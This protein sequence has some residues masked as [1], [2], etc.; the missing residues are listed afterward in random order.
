MAVRSPVRLCVVSVCVCQLWRGPSWAMKIFPC[1]QETKE[2]PYNLWLSDSTRV[3]SY[4]PRCS[5]VRVHSL[6]HLPRR[7]IPQKIGVN[8]RKVW[9]M[10]GAQ[11]AHTT[12]K[13]TLGK[14]EQ[15]EGIRVRKGSFK[16]KEEIK[17]FLY[18]E[19]RQKSRWGKNTDDITREWGGLQVKNVEKA[20][21]GCLCG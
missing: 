2:W 16:V 11:K 10:R 20:R 8:K 1:G 4:F 19:N 5:D 17:V 6:L 13:H 12:V 9:F 21:R 18:R 14:K 3:I 15:K 7:C